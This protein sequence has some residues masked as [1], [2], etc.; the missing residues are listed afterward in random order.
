M[1]FSSQFESFARVL[2]VMSFPGVSTMACKT[3]ISASITRAVFCRPWKRIL[4]AKS[5]GFS[6]ASCS[7]WMA[8]RASSYAC[9]SSLWELSVT[10]LVTFARRAWSSS[11]AAM[12]VVIGR[13]HRGR[14]DSYSYCMWSFS[15]GEESRTQ[16]QQAHP[17]SMLQSTAGSCGT[18]PLMDCMEFWMCSLAARSSRLYYRVRM[19]QAY[20]YRGFVSGGKIRVGDKTK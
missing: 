8:A 13:V 18:P 12:F 20:A 10:A 17:T 9:G 15:Y 14:M 11:C 1:R 5:P 2:E 16:V 7:F 4:A 19:V 3:P 6:T